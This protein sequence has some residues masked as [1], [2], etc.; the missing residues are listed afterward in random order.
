MRIAFITPYMQVGGAETYINNKAKALIENGYEVFVLS[1]GGPFVS[2]LDKKIT[3]FTIENISKPPYQLSFNERKTLTTDLINKLRVNSMDIVELHNVNPIH[4]YLLVFKKLQI[5]FICNF[6]SERALQRNFLLRFALQIIHPSKCLYTLSEQMRRRLSTQSIFHTRF[7]FK[8]IPIPINNPI[9]FS[10][11]L[12]SY[13]KYILSV[14]RLSEEKMYVKC[15]MLDFIDL[16]ANKKK[17]VNYN[18]VIVGDGEYYDELSIIAENFNLLSYKNK[19]YMLGTVFS[20]TLEQLYSSCSL[21]IG[22]GTT[23]IQAASYGKPVLLAG[24]DLDDQS[25][26]WG[27]WG[28]DKN[29][30]QF[31]V[32]NKTK[33]E[34]KKTYLTSLSD[35]FDLS[36]NSLNQYGEKAY[37]VYNTY[38]NAD[39]FIN[40]WL[41]VLDKTVKSTN[42]INWLLFLVYSFLIYIFRFIYKIFK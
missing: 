36:L 18:L 1:E 29:D 23:V 33:N 10:S 15:L 34:Y 25:Y 22:M 3:H 28:T 17:N 24:V 40:Q 31:I 2:S 41:N 8:I 30:Y 4:Y 20:P 5:P 9:Y 14:A 37:Q 38:Y 11:S 35:F 42:K 26:S 27:Y 32:G 6:L 19:I 21:Y 12:N 16:I 7:E 39:S 13:G